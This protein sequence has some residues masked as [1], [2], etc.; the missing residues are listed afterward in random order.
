MITGGSKE[1]SRKLRKVSK[2]IVLGLNTG[3]SAYSI[4][5]ELVKLGRSVKF[6]WVEGLVAGYFT[7][8]ACIAKCRQKSVA[9]A[10]AKK[11][12]RTRVGRRI[13]I[14]DNATDTSL[15]C[16]PVQANGADGFKLALYHI[17]SRLQG[18][19]ARIMNTFYTMR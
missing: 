12:L 10:R 9:G 16:L 5:Q 2:A 11:Q 3:R 6:A 15:F 1:R 4:H 17:S 13:H 14:P 8:F 19:D 18:V 7:K